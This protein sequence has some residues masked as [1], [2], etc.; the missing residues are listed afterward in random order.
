[1]G[2]LDR[3]GENISRMR[4]RMSPL[5]HTDIRAMEEG[6][7]AAWET[8]GEAQSQW[9]SLDAFLQVRRSE[10]QLDETDESSHELRYQLE[11]AKLRA[12]E[13]ERE[14]HDAILQAQVEEVPQ[15]S[16]EAQR[17][18][19]ETRQQADDSQQRAHE[20]EE[21]LLA[22]VR[23][24]EQ[25]AQL[26]E[27]N[28]AEMVKERTQMDERIAAKEE[29]FWAVERE[30][31][32]LQE[33]EELGR[34]GWAVV[35]VAKFRGVSVA[36]KCLH[37]VI[38]SDYNR[39]LFIRE[40]RFASR[41]RHP[42]LLQFIGATLQGEL[43]ILTE[44]MPTCV[45]LLIGERALRQQCISH[46]E[47][48]SISLDIICALNYLHLMKPDP[49]IHRD[50]SSANVLLEPIIDGDWRAKVS[51]YG[52]VKFLRQLT[53]AGPGNPVYAAPEANSPLQQSH[54]MDIF[55]FGILLLEMACC[56]FPDPSARNCHIALVHQPRLV[57]LIEQCTSADCDRHPSAGDL[58]AQIESI[59]CEFPSV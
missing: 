23:S 16:E 34:G 15:Q 45:R 54:K 14:L 6:M 17:Q 10:K 40:M 59:T 55:S 50:I 20:R 31:I 44:L 36:A 35:K 18:A 38:A 21:G 11:E 53:T 7:R 25:R 51:D 52:S 56:R 19:V 2:T 27:L 48:T 13:L 33:G 26:A 12:V 58:I 42:N 3:L 32:E 9:Q 39:E 1:M 57:S 30:E 47:V 43:V 46:R 4:D 24:A 28:M 8:N 22:Q 49:I 5:V 37:G 41:V 29:P